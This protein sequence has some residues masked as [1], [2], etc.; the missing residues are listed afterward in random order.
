MAKRRKYV[1]MTVVVSVPQWLSTADARREV[2][3]MINDRCGWRSDLDERDVKAI[4]VR[5]APNRKARR[6]IT[7][8]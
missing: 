4:A 6:R 8:E 7:D 5:A 2:R 3:T 1:A